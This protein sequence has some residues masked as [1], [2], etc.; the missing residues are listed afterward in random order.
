MNNNNTRTRLYSD[1]A[2]AFTTLTEDAAYLLKK[3]TGFNITKNR[4]L[5]LCI[6]YP[7]G[8][9]IGHISNF[10]HLKP[11][12]TT[13]AVDSLEKD[14]YLLRSSDSGDRRSIIIKPTNKAIELLETF[15]DV[16]KTHNK[17]VKNLIGDQNY[18]DLKQF[19]LSGLDNNE[20]LETLPPYLGGYFLRLNH[21][22]NILLDT[23]AFEHEN[24]LSLIEA[25]LL[26]LRAAMPEETHLTELSTILCVRPN[27]ISIS[28][29]SLVEKGLV[30]RIADEND[31][32]ATRLEL[33][34]KG[35]ELIEATTDRAYSVFN[36]YFP[37]MLNHVY[38]ELLHHNIKTID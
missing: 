31:R 8:L 25:R 14:G 32:R 5:I 34:D 17:F 23:T 1:W 3:A 18:N 26:R 4:I 29:D 12:T 19:L 13:A 2:T 30:K 11:S 36:S 16:A 38:P 22:I 10:L 21:M 24:G 27:V 15:N 7:E 9:R 6:G 35:K 37:D 28:V 20:P 33:L